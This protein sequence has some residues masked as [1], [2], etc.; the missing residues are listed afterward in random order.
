MVN[1]LAVGNIGDGKTNYVTMRAYMAS[2]KGRKVF[3]NYSMTFSDGYINLD[4][5]AD[6]LNVEKYHGSVLNVDE[7]QIWFDSRNFG[8]PLNKLFSY[9]FLQA[10]H[11]RL[12]FNVTAQQSQLVDIRFANN[13]DFFCLCTAMVYDQDLGILREATIYEI[14]A[15]V[16]EKIRVLKVNMR[17][18]TASYFFYDPRPYFSMYNT[19]QFV[20]IEGGSGGSKA[21]NYGGSR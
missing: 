16:I 14:E 2:L 3:G 8:K 1:T 20:D 4:E 13:F 9:I 11:R 21:N 18:G 17:D 5:V 19:L 6:P 12:D 7:G 10:R 15:Q